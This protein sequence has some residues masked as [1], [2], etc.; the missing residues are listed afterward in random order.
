MIFPELSFAPDRRSVQTT[1]YHFSERSSGDEDK[2][3][4]SQHDSLVWALDKIYQ[5][6]FTN[7][8]QS[9]RNTLVNIL[10]SEIPLVHHNL[11]MLAAANYIVYYMRSS[12]LAPLETDPSKFTGG[13]NDHNRQVFEAFFDFVAP[14][15]ITDVS[16]KTPEEILI[17]RAEFKVTLLRYIIFVQE[18]TKNFMEE[19]V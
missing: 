3:S 10:V 5:S 18:N 14:F 8:S 15:I 9:L 2:R 4:F 13:M 7:I 11:T 17:V 16:G 19:K 12:K 6:K 1:F